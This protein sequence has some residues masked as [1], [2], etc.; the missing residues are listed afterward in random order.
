MLTSG[1][2]EIEEKFQRGD[3]KIPEGLGGQPDRSPVL[4]QSAVA[5]SPRWTRAVRRLP[6]PPLRNLLAYWEGKEREG[7]FGLIGRLSHVSRTTR[8]IIQH[9]K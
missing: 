6:K 8:S 1:N 4:A 2:E 5:D 7:Y 9:Y 3:G